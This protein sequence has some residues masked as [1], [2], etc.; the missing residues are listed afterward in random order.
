ML[1]SKV[2]KLTLPTN[3][4]TMIS[5]FPAFD[6]NGVT[7]RLKPTVPY[8]D[9]VSKSKSNGSLPDSIWI[10]KKV[11]AMM[12]NMASVICANALDTAC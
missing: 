2:Y 5:H 9:T 12:N 11:I 8:A 7:F 3:I 10:I 6:K 4:V 1:D